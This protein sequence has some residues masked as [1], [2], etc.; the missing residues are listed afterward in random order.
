M[1]F[2]DVVRIIEANGFV[3]SRHHGTSHRQ[4]RG[5]IGGQVRYVTIACHSQGDDVKPKTLAS[6]IRQSGLPKK[7]S[8][9]ATA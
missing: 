5:T 7:T 1:K 4:Y 6:I 8:A 9:E 3:L 2:R